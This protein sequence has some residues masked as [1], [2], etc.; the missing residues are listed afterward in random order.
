MQCIKG[1]D[2]Q[3][4]LAN[5]CYKREELAAAGVQVIDKEYKYTILQ[6]IPSE[7]VTFILHLLFSALITHGAAHINLNTLIHLICEEVDWLK[8][9]GIYR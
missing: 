1:E 8:S 4:F 2:I 3:K 9:Q 7:L 6:G 5:L